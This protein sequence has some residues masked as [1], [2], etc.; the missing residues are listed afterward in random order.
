MSRDRYEVYSVDS[1][2]RPDEGVVHA[3]GK[4]AVTQAQ[5]EVREGIDRSAKT[6]GH[7]VVTRKS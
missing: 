3:H 2:G 5:R 4:D 7:T 6:R 1:N